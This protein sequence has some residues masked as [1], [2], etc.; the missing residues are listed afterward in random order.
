MHHNFSCKTL[1]EDLNAL[2][3]SIS[4]DEVRRFLTSVA[5]DELKKSDVYIPRGISSF[6]KDNLN[7]VIDAAMDNFDQNGDTLDGKSSTHCMAV[8]LYQRLS[9]TEEVSGIPRQS[10]KSLDTLEYEEPPIQRYAKPH[11]WPEPPSSTFSVFEV[12]RGDSYVYSQLSADLVWMVAQ[13]MK[14]Q[15]G[16]GS[17]PVTTIRYLPFVNALPSDFSTIYSTL[18]KLVMIAMKLGKDTSVLQPI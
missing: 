9:K 17:I 13:K 14:T 11:K 1:I 18:L 15:A 8:V 7:S 16:A 10:L 5:K 3:Y 6:D 4:Y 2:G 12:K